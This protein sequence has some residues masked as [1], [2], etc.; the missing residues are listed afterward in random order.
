MIFNLHA[1]INNNLV[2]VNGLISFCDART[3]MTRIEIIIMMNIFFSF[4]LQMIASICKWDDSI[5]LWSVVVDE[6][7][8]FSNYEYIFPINK[9]S[10]RTFNRILLILLLRQNNKWWSTIY[11]QQRRDRERNKEKNENSSNMKLTQLLWYSHNRF[12][13]FFYSV[14]TGTWCRFIFFFFIFTYLQQSINQA[15]ICLLTYIIFFCICFCRFCYSYFFM[16]FMFRFQFA[17]RLFR[18]LFTIESI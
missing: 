4:C 9:W 2:D 17:V 6:N 18:A 1:F 14:A 5:Q 10:S 13:R 15:T 12:D 16:I 7:F 11:W 3:H 8:H